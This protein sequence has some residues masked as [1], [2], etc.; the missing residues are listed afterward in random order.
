MLPADLESS[1]RQTREHLSNRLGRYLGD[2]HVTSLLRQLDTLEAELKSDPVVPVALLGSTGSGKS[3]LLNALLQF[4]ILPVSAMKPC[5]SVVTTVRSV[6][7]S[8]YRAEVRFLTQQEWELELGISEDILTSG[9]DDPTDPG[10]SD[11]IRKSVKAKLKA[12]YQVDDT[13]LEHPHEVRSLSLPADLTELMQ[14]GSPPRILTSADAKGLKEQLREYLSGEH[15]Y[16]PLV[17]IVDITGPFETLPRGIQLVDL[18]G[19]NDPNEAREEV[20]RRY[21]RESPYLWALFNIKRGLTKDVRTMLLEQKL[22]RQLLLDGKVHALTL[23][24]T[25]ADEIDT[26]DETLAELGL[27]AEATVRDAILAR[28]ERVKR[29]FRDELMDI[30]AELARQAGEANDGLRRLQDSLSQTCVFTVSTKAYLRLVGAL[31]GQKDYG[32]DDPPDTQVPQLRGHLEEIARHQGIEERNQEVM[33]KLDLLLQ[34]IQSQFRARRA[35]LSQRSEGLVEELQRI[36]SQIEGPREQLARDLAEVQHDADGDFRN[37]QEHLEDR[38]DQAVERALK[39]IGLQVDG[40]GS[41]HWATLRAIVARDGQFLSPSTGKR[42]DLNASLAEPLL[43]AIPFAWDDFF[44]RQLEK[45]TTWARGKL[46]RHI[47]VYL[48]RL[49]LEVV[50]SQGFTEETVTSLD[51]DMKTARQSLMLQIDQAEAGLKRTIEERRRQLAAGILPTV[52]SV[53]TPAY[54]RCRQERGPGMKHRIL[55][56]VQHHAK[57]AAERIFT[58]IRSD[59]REGVSELGVQLSGEIDQV[60][61]YA[62]QQADRVRQNL[63]GGRWLSEVDNVQAGLLELDQLSAQVEGLRPPKAKG[64]GAAAGSKEEL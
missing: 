2:D 36:Q 38:L 11:A 16:W 54:E 48:E 10:E 39:Q 28:N 7:E 53:M 18:P 37:R 13:T 43:Q 4:Q 30:A 5:T 63:G 22:L 15:R 62:L 27:D 19:V 20:T 55:G 25:H 49:K 21:L 50:R 45:I 1:L 60:A 58:T 42:H 61:Q 31:G 41:L 40:W 46:E 33:T 64:A 32:L 57:D 3:T 26:D 9:V 59:I 35:I 56:V 12:V 47:D 52:S 8:S 34:E 17:K 44:G 24:G 29:D 23:I 6:A 14:P 51:E